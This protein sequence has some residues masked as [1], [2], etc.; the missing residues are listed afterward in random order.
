MM[1]SAEVVE[2]AR[3]EGLGDLAED[4]AGWVRPGWRLVPSGRPAA[5]GVSKVG[6]SP[7]LAAGETWPMSPRGIPLGFVAQIDCDALPPIAP[8]WQHRL[9][10]WRHSGR[11]VRLFID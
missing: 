6:G 3:T 11:L 5:P 1:S 8:E 4:L 7:D 2:L 9:R 10:P